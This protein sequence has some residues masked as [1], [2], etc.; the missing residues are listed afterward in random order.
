MGDPELMHGA[1]DEA[2]SGSGLRRAGVAAAVAVLALAVVAVGLA[3]ARRPRPAAPAAQ[4]A[5]AM[6]PVTRGTVTQR[7][8][9]AGVL[10]FDGTYPVAHQGQPG[11]LTAA[12]RP[13]SVVRRGGVLYRVDNQAV[14]LLFGT[15]PVYRD[16]AAG[17]PDGPDVHQLEQNLAALR[18]DPGRVDQRFTG[19][20]AAA[21][22]RW[23]T[24][25]GLPAWRRTGALPL[26]AVV[27]AP[28]ALRIGQVPAVVG[29]SVAPDAPVLAATSTRRVVTAQLPADR[30]S[31][32]HAGDKVRVTVGGASAPVPGTVVRVGRVAATPETD[33]GGADGGSQPATVTV[34][35]RADLP[36]G[37]DLDRAPAQLAI[38]TA[39]H[40]DVLLVPVVALL[41]APGDGYHVRLA[42]GEYVRVRPGLFDSTAGTVEVRGELTVGQLVQV[43]AP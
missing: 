15:I 25:W 10:G 41:P 39:V 6:A 16:L 34:T 17:M 20:T 7:I 21:I 32:V 22:R 26:G 31:L 3:V 42:S 24:R 40:R 38:T 33:Q 19:A 13:G 23:Q 27:F 28:V 2:T 35:I 12:A 18:L 29:T 11:I 30:Q 5:T 8:Q 14:R 43:P 9:I 4:V 37:G 36:A 1:R